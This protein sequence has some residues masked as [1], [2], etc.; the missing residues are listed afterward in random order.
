MVLRWNGTNQANYTPVALWNCMA[1]PL[2]SQNLGYAT[3]GFGGTFV[4]PYRP[5]IMVGSVQ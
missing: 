3:A 5:I 4:G 2:A 1:A